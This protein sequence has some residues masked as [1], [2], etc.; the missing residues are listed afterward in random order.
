MML[1]NKKP[2]PL[3]V[4]GLSGAGM[5]SVLKAL[6]DMGYEAFDNFPLALVD[7]LLKETGAAPVAIGL[8]TRTRGFEIKA[9]LG[10]VER[11]GAQLV[12]VRCDENVLQKRFTETRRRHPLAAGKSLTTGIRQEKEIL[13]PLR[14]KADLVIDSSYMSI[15]DLR[16]LLEG[17]FQVERKKHLTITLLS[18]G[19]R[20]GLPREAD[21]VM[22]VRFLKNPHWEP[23][24]KTKTGQSKAVANYIESDPDLAGFMKKFQ[25]LIKP[26]LPRYLKEGKSYLTIAVGCTGGK[27]RSVYVAEQMAKWLKSERYTTHI[28]HRDMPA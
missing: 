6:E 11:L 21:I 7:P 23:K 8:D 1:K 16:H 5:S 3:I 9:V 24:L 22:D 17:H 19:F 12:F 15:H 26:L 20:N 10:T 25:G 28:D 14:A 27:H 13:K 4:T 18:F 2:V